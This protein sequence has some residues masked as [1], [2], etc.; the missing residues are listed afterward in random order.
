MAVLACM[1]CGPNT[2]VASD[3]IIPCLDEPT[4]MSMNV[5]DIVQCTIDP[6]TDTDLFRFEGVAGEVIMLT[7]TDQTGGS[8]H[9]LA[10]IYNPDQVSI[11]TM[12]NNDGG[13][14]RV[15]ELLETGTYT[16][17]IREN[18]D[19]QT[20]TYT[21]AL[22]S[23]FPQPEETL[24]LC[25]DCVMTQSID[26]VADSDV[27]RFEGESGMTIMLTLTD[28]TGGSGHPIAELFDPDEILIDTLV[29][30]DGGTRLLLDLDKT[31]AYTMLMRENGDNQVA[32]YTLAL[33][34]LVPEA[35]HAEYLVYGQ[36]VQGAI[37]PVA[38]SDL[39]VIPGEAGTTILLTLTDTTGGSGHPIL[40]IFDPS[41]QLIETLVQNDGA[42][43]WQAT[44]A[45]S[46][47]YILLVRENGD[48]Q[49]ATFNLGLQCLFGD[50]PT[51]LSTRSWG[52]VKSSY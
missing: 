20:A 35:A 7:L 33:Q 1:L 31:G 43:T 48:N 49:T 52:Q 19:N 13:I 15:F 25:Y 38:D 51:T 9:P 10:E 11:D 17:L 18:G 34:Q 50:C 27:I 44:L 40:E 30:N 8:G 3:E 2:G 46:G 14:R 22:Q 29:H 41:H 36:V 16:I 37:D 42:D 28:R 23:L 26:V 6:V 12:V 39:Y 21:I 32:T 47:N 24:A 45:D 4:D 5:G